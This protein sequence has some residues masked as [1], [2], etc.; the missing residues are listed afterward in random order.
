MSST[1]C[2]V[3]GCKKP[4]VVHV[5]RAWDHRIGQEAHC[6]ADDIRG[7]L[8][9]YYAMSFVGEGTSR[10]WRGGVIFD[11]EMLMYDERPGKPCQFS[12]REVGGSRRLDCRIGPFEAMALLWELQRYVAPRPLTH[13]AMASLI[14]ALGGRLECVEIDKFFPGQEVAYE[15]KLHIQQMSSTRIV[16]VRPSDAMPLAVTCDVPIVVSNAVLAGLGETE[17]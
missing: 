9:G 13:R 5:H 2:I 7:F 1:T 8:D 17:R 12:L 6:C 16:D 11:I 3:P 15:A 14:T 4:T 10:S